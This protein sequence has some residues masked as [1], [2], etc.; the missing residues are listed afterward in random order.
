MNRVTQK[1]LQDGL[2]IH[3]SSVP[4]LM[5]GGLGG[6]DLHLQLEPLE[7]AD[8]GTKT[9]SDDISVEIRKPGHDWEEIGYVGEGY[10]FYALPTSADRAVFMRW[11]SDLEDHTDE[12]LYPDDEGEEG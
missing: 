6:C 8:D 3:C 10:M 1:S 12:I 7:I 11:L 5:A 2:V 4:E 9:W